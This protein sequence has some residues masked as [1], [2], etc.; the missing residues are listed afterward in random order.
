MMTVVLSHVNVKGKGICIGN[1]KSQ[2]P[3]RKT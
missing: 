1:W 2:L 3:K